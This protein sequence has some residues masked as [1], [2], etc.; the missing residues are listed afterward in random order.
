MATLTETAYWTRKTINIGIIVAVAV[1]ILRIVVGA[2]TDL[3]QKFFPPPP[4]P[5]NVAFGRLPSPNGQNNLATPSGTITYTLETADGTLPAMPNTLRVYFMPRPGPSFGSFDRMKSVA[6]RLGFS[7]I[8]LR[9]GPVTWRFTDKDNPLRV[10]DIDEVSGNFR[11]TYGYISDQGIFS[12]ARFTSPEQLISE[13]RSYFDN[14]GLLPADFKGGQAPV[15]YYKFDAGV[16]MPTT[17]IANAEAVGVT[18]FRQEL[19]SGSTYGKIPVL[20]P[21]LR[22]GLVSVLFS[23]SPDSKKR[24]LEARFLAVP[25]A[26]ENWATY[27]PMSSA[28][29]WEKLKAGRAIFGSLPVPI[30]DKITVRKIYIAYLDPYPS[31]SYLQPVLVFSDEKGFAAYVPLTVN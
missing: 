2:S 16:L 5:P 26:L 3:W 20:S 25:V 22:Q 18:L 31:Q 24:I 17:A 9:I 23:A 28:D 10:L 21:D 4:P 6:S 7:D 8:P 1:I 14:L 12:E 19:E 13:A 15:T 11:L 29:A 27:T 30:T